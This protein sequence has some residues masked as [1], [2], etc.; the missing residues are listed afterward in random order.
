MIRKNR[1]KLYIVS[2]KH[3]GDP[4]LTDVQHKFFAVRSC[5]NVESINK[6]GFKWESSISP[7]NL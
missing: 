3:L 6:Y 5:K 2:I 1:G 4:V 7:N